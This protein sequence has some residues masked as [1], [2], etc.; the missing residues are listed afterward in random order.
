[1]SAITILLA[2]ALS[3]PALPPAEYDDTEVVT[4][5]AL[6]SLRAD[7]R[8]FSFRLELDATPSNNVSLVFGRDANEDGVLSRS[9]EALLVGWDCGM[10]K[11]VDCATGEEIVEQGAAGRVTLDWRLV[12]DPQLSPHSLESSVGGLPVFVALGLNPPRFLF[13]AGWDTA[14]VV[15]RGLDAPNPQVDCAAD[16]LPLLI[17]IR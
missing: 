12:A 4:N 13:D 5:V 2:A 3:F 11:V 6:P 15:C 8:V 16:S 10:W 1:M 17:R 7:S 14:K 9:E